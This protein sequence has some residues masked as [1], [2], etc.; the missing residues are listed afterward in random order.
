MSI[1]KNGIIKSVLILLQFILLAI[2]AYEGAGILYKDMLPENPGKP[3]DEQENAGTIPD[4]KEKTV[5]ASPLKSYEI[6][7][8]RNLFDVRVQK[9]D[10]DGRENQTQNTEAVPLKK[11]ELKLALW[12]TVISESSAGSYAVIENQDTREQALYQTG[13]TVADAVIKQILRNKI[14]LTLDNQ[15]QVLEVDDS[16]HPPG[17]MTS[18]LPLP[19]LEEPLQPLSFHPLED[20]AGE[21]DS[22]DIPD[23]MKQVRI[24]PYFSN[25][26]L[27]GALLYGIKDDSFLHA[28]GFRNGDII[29]TVDGNEISSPGEALAVLQA[30][31]EGKAG[32]QTIPA[33]LLRQ[34]KIMEIML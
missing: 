4:Q 5:A 28:A 3:S 14:I 21:S 31:Q 1:T 2:A 20:P 11:T 27:S 34:G 32:S 29:Q 23:L 22:G 8:T 17:P 19:E 30:L 7:S 24:R 25:G 16:K 13:D 9:P 12:G 10:P 26:K 6:I 15:D 18:A 33:T